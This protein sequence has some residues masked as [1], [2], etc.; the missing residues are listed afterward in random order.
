MN[1]RPFIL[2]CILA[3]MFASCSNSRD[4]QQQ[5]EIKI[6]KQNYVNALLEGNGHTQRLAYLL[7][8]H[9]KETEVSDQVVVD[10]HSKY[11]LDTLQLN[12]CLSTFTAQ[13]GWSDINYNDTKRS[14]WEP[15]V[16]ADRL[17]LMAKFLRSDKTSFH[18]NARLESS[19]HQALQFWFR[20]DPICPNWWYNEIGVPKTMGEFLILFEPYLTAE[21]KEKAIAIMKRSNIGMTGQNRVWLA[22]NVLI[23]ALLQHDHALMKECRNVIMAEITNDKEEGIQADWSFHQH[24]SMQQFGNYGL[25][26]LMSM[27]FYANLFN[28]TTLSFTGDKLKILTEF[29]GQ[30]YRWTLWNG[31]MDLNTLTRQFFKNAP[32]DKG[33]GVGFAA[34]ELSS[35]TT[36]DRRP[37]IDSL[38]TDNYDTTSR[39]QGTSFVGFKHFWCSDYTT[40]RRPQWMAS[41]RM[42]SDRV[43]GTELVNEDNLKG[44]YSG[45]GA[46]F[47]YR[48]GTEY[49]NI[50]PFWDWRKI[51]GVTAWDT[52]APLPE[53]KPERNNRGTFTGGVAAGETGM[54]V[55]QLDR[56][57]L[58]AHKTWIMEKDF[59]LCLGSDIHADTGTPVTTGIEQCF[60][61]NDFSCFDGKRW[62]EVKAN[63]KQH[64]ERRYRIN[65]TGYILLDNNAVSAYVEK[66]RGRWCDIMGMYRPDTL[67][68][69]MAGLHINHG[70]VNRTAA[71]YA[72]A[73]LPGQSCEAVARFDTRNIHIIRND[74]EAHAVQIG[75]S[76][77]YVA[78]FRPD[79]CFET[80]LMGTLHCE[81][82][83][84]FILRLQNGTPVLYAADPEQ[85]SDRLQGLFQDQPFHLDF[86]PAEKGTTKHILLTSNQ[87]Q[88][89]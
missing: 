18:N 79:L 16:H 19:I 23:R 54:S 51:P 86:S 41:L 65:E 2:L 49:L 80:S 38:F 37:M 28:G 84:L 3:V 53:M 12:S 33:M 47:I 39:Q 66:R 70:P 31:V 15:K 24:G 50:M 87:A 69:C 13:G 6:I 42:S 71:S 56:D 17:L 34:A 1:R 73:V 25:S 81:T 29:I 8:T 5:K 48:T 45:D 27:S 75:D 57:G 62:N 30:G 78:A 40:H 7:E 85:Q 44:Y 58:H 10:V 46:F 36:R 63:D 52:D 82:S 77:L 11:R 89:Q 76:I 22:G 83:G 14:G 64:G 26:Y 9:V 72:Y 32:V 55:M 4:R 74:R 61:K 59:V 21:E 67:E 60:Y 35:C 43:Q 68:A 20:Q 88:K